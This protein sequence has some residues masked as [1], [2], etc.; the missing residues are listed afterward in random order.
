[1]DIV[2]REFSKET[3]YR[4]LEQLQRDV[5][6]IIDDTEVV[7]MHMLITIQENGGVVLGAFDKENNKLIGFVFG[8][9][10]LTPNGHLKHCSHMAGIAERFRDQHLGVRLKLAQREFVLSQSIDLITWTF[11]PL[12][13]RNAYLNFHKLGGISNNFFRDLYGEIRDEVSGGL[14][15]D[16]LY[17]E[18]NICSRR[19]AERINNL[20]FK[21]IEAK[22][23]YENIVVRGEYKNGLLYPPQKLPSINTQKLYYLIPHDI[24]VIRGT[25]ISLVREWHNFSRDFFEKAFSQNYTVTD[26]IKVEDESYYLLEKDWSQE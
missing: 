14:P 6:G 10:G 15:S 20:F 13:S 25:D 19:V 21:N 1:M 4:D 22:I 18:W 7:P 23:V 2:I 26:F 24:S 3:E 12:E 5:W 8:F 9:L 11:D 16:R 17:L